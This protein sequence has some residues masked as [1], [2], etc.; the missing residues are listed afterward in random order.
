M[1][2][3]YEYKRFVCPKNN[4]EEQG[5][6]IDMTTRELGE[7]GWI[8][9]GFVIQK[10]VGLTGERPVLIFMREKEG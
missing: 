8:L 10:F 1:S 3:Q 7:E 5:E 2:K 6:W 4:D 9:C